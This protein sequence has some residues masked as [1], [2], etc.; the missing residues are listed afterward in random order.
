MPTEVP[1]SDAV[2]NL[3]AASQLVLGIQRSDLTLISRGLAD[4]LHQP[5]RAHLYP[6][7]MELLPRAR[8]FG[9][10]GATV[11]GAGP[12]MLFWCFWQDTGKVTEALRGQVEGWASVTRAPFSPLGADVPEL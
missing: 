7:S 12:A 2:A 4:R 9:A 8:E 11:S 3:A 1:V 5:N 6:R 10:I